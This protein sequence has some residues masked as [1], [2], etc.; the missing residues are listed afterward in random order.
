LRRIAQLRHVRPDVQVSGIRGNVD[1]R[2]RK[3]DA[4]DYDALVLAE[5]G[6]ERL[7]LTAKIT[8][9][10]PKSV[11][12]PAVGQGALG[13]EVRSDDATALAAIAALDDPATRAAVVAERAMLA[14]LSGGC[15][16]PIGAWGRIEDGRLR[17][18][19]VVLDPEGKQRLA[20]DGVGSATAPEDLGRAVAD[21]LL[22]Q[23]A[24]ALIAA[25]RDAS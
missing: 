17:L 2:L 25:A 5:A 15:L 3:L 22:A 12:L 6:L 19:G 24:A 13:L 7:G 21:D 23:G 9:V 10:L 4:G 20:A 18:E 16:A 11:M 8:Q 1:T 14:H